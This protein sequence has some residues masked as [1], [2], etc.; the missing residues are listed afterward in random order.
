MGF[1]RDAVV[2]LFAGF[3]IAFLKKLKEFNNI[4]EG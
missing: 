1:W 4:E 3:I 2:S